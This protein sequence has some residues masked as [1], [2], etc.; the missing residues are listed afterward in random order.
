LAEETDT[1]PE[2]RVAT[3][4]S[5]RERI[6]E[7]IEAIRQGRLQPLP[8]ARVLERVHEIIALADDLAGDFRRVR[9]RFEQLNRDLRERLMD[10]DATGCGG[11]V[12][13]GQGGGLRSSRSA[14]PIETGV[15]FLESLAAVARNAPDSGGLSSRFRAI[16][17]RA[18]RFSPSHCTDR[19]IQAA[20]CRRSRRY[21]VRLAGL[22]R[23]SAGLDCARFRCNES[24]MGEGSF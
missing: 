15:R 5:E 1:N 8:E 10:N 19:W 6:D 21:R 14:A 22:L 23:G 4:L 9:D 17:A 16:H 11:A 3:L 24:A 13:S 7:Q 2:T 20:S 12:A 18:V